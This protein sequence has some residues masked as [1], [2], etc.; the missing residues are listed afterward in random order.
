MAKTIEELQIICNQF[1][2][3]YQSASLSTVSNDQL[4]LASYAPFVYYNNTYYFLISQIAP[5]YQ[6]LK[7]HSS[8]S[9]NL[10]QDESK[11]AN[12]FFRQR[13]TY[14]AKA[15]FPE[16]TDELKQAFVERFGEMAT[17]LFGLDFV[18]VEA[19]I[20]HGSMVLG[21]GQAYQIN[22]KQEVQEQIKSPHG[23]GHKR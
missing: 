10:L 12:I 4:P 18:V 16:V 22:A 11:A 5:H 7:V 21:A 19:D 13:L 9:F 20:L 14:Q 3:T 23:H 2:H 8:F 17:M 6:N 1:P 15:H